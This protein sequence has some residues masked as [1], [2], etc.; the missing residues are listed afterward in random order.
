MLQRGDTPYEWH[1]R[2][3]IKLRNLRSP[4]VSDLIEFRASLLAIQKLGKFRE[5]T[6]ET[7]AKFLQIAQKNIMTEIKDKDANNQKA[8]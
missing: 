3:S 2:I 7:V 5:L 6:Q 4:T 1:R 8:Y